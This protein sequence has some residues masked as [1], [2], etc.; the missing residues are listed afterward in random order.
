MSEYRL[1]FDVIDRDHPLLLASLKILVEDYTSTGMFDDTLSID[2][3]SESLE[4][5]IQ[6]TTYED[7]MR[8]NDWSD[9]T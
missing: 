1:V 7:A 6:N 5:A 3:E 4:E 8:W 2:V 9:Q